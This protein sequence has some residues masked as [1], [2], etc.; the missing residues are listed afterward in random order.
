MK[1]TLAASLFL[2]AL[3]GI[4]G[5]VGAE[6]RQLTGTEIAAWIAGNTVVGDWAG[7]DYRQYF[8][9]KRSGR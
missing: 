8:S 1:R 6:E 4:A 5:A 9:D 2:V 7:S 3:L